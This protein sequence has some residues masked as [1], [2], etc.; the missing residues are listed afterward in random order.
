MTYG[1]YP[2]LVAS[3]L[4]MTFFNASLDEI[5]EHGGDAWICFIKGC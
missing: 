2:Q 4:S 5:G 3:S 1:T